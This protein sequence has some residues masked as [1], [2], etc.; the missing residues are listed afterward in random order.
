M[1]II[2]RKTFTAIPQ[3]H[4]YTL[5]Q[6]SALFPH[7]VSRVFEIFLFS[8]I[9]FFFSHKQQEI[10]HKITLHTTLIRD[11]IGQGLGFSIAGG[12]G[13]P[14]F[15][16]GSDGIY[17]SRITEGGLAHRDGKILVGDKVL[18][19]RSC[20]GLHAYMKL[21]LLSLLLSLL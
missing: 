8:F 15:K 3:T 11:Q 9:S 19:V 7:L 2:E 21:Q 5:I 16:D 6:F 4:T 20:F 17:I 1:K 18:V 10:T 13:S 12:K 14:P